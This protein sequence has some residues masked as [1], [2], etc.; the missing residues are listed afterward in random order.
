MIKHNDYCI[1]LAGGSGK[2]L[3]PVSR[4]IYP[5]QFMDLFGIGRSLLQQT[6]DR[7]AE[8]IPPEHIFVATY[9]GYVDLPHRAD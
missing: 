5:K 3:W 6:Y 8:I 4:Q 1:I 2:R 9:A 7:F